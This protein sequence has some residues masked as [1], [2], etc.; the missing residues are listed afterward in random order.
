[1]WIRRSSGAIP[2]ASRGIWTASRL[3]MLFTT[4]LTNSME[5]GGTCILSVGAGDVVSALPTV[6]PPQTAR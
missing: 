6:S 3:T 4:K 5:A 2:S 1:M